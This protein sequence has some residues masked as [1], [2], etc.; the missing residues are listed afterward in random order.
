MNY[1]L[2]D[3]HDRL[4]VQHK[5]AFLVAKGATIEMK[6]VGKQRTGRQNNSLH[7][8]FELLAQELSDAGYDMKK[9][10]RADADIPWTPENIKEFLWRP[11]MKAQTQKTSTTEL[12][13]KE[14]DEIYDTLTRHLGTKLGFPAVPFPSIETMEG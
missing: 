4:N 6:E 7:R 2:N 9:T 1:N 3:E 12:T 10:L 5:L 14:I 13:T 11:V 8:Y